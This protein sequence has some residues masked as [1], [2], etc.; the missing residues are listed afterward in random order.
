MAFPVDANQ[1]AVS[2]PWAVR[3]ESYTA[4]GNAGRITVYALMGGV[5]MFKSDEEIVDP[6]ML[7]FA[8]LRGEVVPVYWTGRGQK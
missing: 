6:L 3:K 2:G 5:R 1:P 7:D 4:G 8:R